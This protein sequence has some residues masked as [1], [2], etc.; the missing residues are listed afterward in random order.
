MYTVQISVLRFAKIAARCM[1]I[2]IEGI[3]LNLLILI[4]PIL[5]TYLALIMMVCGK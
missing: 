3:L 5:L 2:S 1:M 4:V